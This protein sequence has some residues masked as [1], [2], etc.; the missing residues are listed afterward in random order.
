MSFT[1]N[2]NN[3]NNSLDS[4][5]GN[6]DQARYRFMILHNYMSDVLLY[7]MHSLSLRFRMLCK[8]KTGVGDC[9]NSVLSKFPQHKRYGLM[10]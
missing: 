2:V 4:G 6:L 7:S 8:T 3:E 1:L 5:V 9:V 10:Y